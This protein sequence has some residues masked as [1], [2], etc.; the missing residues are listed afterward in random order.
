MKMAAFALAILALFSSVRL[1]W[2][3]AFALSNGIFTTFNVPGAYPGTTI[4]EG[5]ND[6]GQIVGYYRNSTGQ[7][8]FLDTNGVFATIDVPSST[9]TV[10]LGIN[11]AGEIV[12]GTNIGGG[13]HGILDS[14]GVFSTVDFPGSLASEP[15]GINGVGQI[16]GSVFFLQL[17]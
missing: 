11:N 7:H 12:G 8:G 4:A 5:V 1:A 13:P 3:D 14:N 6:A 9:A 16:V 15:Y 2:A 10:A 17:C